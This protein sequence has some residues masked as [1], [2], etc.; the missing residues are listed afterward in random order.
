MKAERKM[1]MHEG[2]IEKVDKKPSKESPTLDR[3]N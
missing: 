3:K 1:D 2:M